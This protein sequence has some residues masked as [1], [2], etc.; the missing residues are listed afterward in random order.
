MITSNNRLIVSIGN[1]SYAMSDT[2]QRTKIYPDQRIVYNR[3]KGVTPWW[4]MLLLRGYIEKKS[5]QSAFSVVLV[6]KL[7]N[8]ESKGLNFS[9]F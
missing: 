8:G 3:M 7:P 2:Q 1:A 4:T 9:P 6:S 5:V